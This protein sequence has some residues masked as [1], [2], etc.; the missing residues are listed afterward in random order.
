MLALIMFAAMLRYDGDALEWSVLGI[1]AA[2]RG[3]ST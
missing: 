3:A 2:N 1:S